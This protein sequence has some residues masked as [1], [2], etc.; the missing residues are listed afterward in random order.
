MVLPSNR[1]ILEPVIQYFC[2]P[3]MTEFNY[4]GLLFLFNDSSFLSSAF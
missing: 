2:L 4:D 1:F 3:I